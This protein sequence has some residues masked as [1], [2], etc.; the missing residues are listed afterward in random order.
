MKKAIFSWIGSLLTTIALSATSAL[1]Q[2]DGVDVSTP[3]IDALAF[4][5]N[6][7]FIARNLI[8]PFD[9]Q[10]T[11]AFTN[12][13]QLRAT[14]VG[15]N[16]GVAGFRFE[17]IDGATSLR[18]LASIIDL[19][20][21]SSI[22]FGNELYLRATNIIQRGTI[23]GPVDGL[24][25]I[26]GKSVDL[27]RGSLE[28][29]SGPDGQ[30]S[31]NA[32]PYFVPDFLIGDTYWGISNVTV[33]ANSLVTTN[34]GSSYIAR[35]PIFDVLSL[36][37]PAGFKDSI[38]ILNGKVFAFT[39]Q[40]T[41]TNQI[42]QVVVVGN[43]DTNINVSVT[44]AP[45]IHLDNNFKTVY[46]QLS[47]TVTNIIS[48]ATAIR[49]LILE[50]S[51]ASDTNS[52]YLTNFNNGLTV[53]PSNFILAR[54]GKTGTKGPNINFSPNL[55]KNYYDSTLFTNGTAYSN[56][57]VTNI[58]YSAYAA[59]VDYQLSTGLGLAGVSPTNTYGRIDIS[60]DNL[61]LDH[62]RI[63]S[64]QVTTIRAK[65]ISSTTASA[66]DAPFLYYDLGSTNGNLAVTNLAA[67]QIK[68][69]AQGG[70]RAFSA[71]F[72]NGVVYTPP[73]PPTN[74][75]STNTDG[76][77]TNAVIYE[78]DFH[79]LFVD[80]TLGLDALTQITG[81]SIRSTNAI[82]S[83]Q[84]SVSDSFQTF[85]DSLTIDGALSLG[86]AGSSILSRWSATNAPTLRFF[87]NHGV[88]T[89]LGGES[90]GRDRVQPYQSWV[91]TGTNLTTGALFN[92]LNWE[93]DGLLQSYFSGSVDI[94]ANYIKIGGGT[95][96]A[97]PQPGSI[98]NVLISGNY[99]KLNGAV[100]N[101]GNVV[102]GI[103]NSVSDAGIGDPNRISTAYG[104]TV[105]F[106]PSSGDLPGTTV[107][108][109]APKFQSP[110]VVW[111]G[112]DRGPNPAG[113]SDN[114]SVGKLR[115]TSQDQGFIT[116][117]PSTGTKAIYV[118]VLDIAPN[119]AAALDTF[120]AVDPNFTIYFADSTV[121]VSQ[122]DGAL[123]GRIQWVPRYAGQYSGV[124]VALQ[125][126][127]TVRVNRNLLN[128]PTI[129]S[130]GD[131]VVNAL[132]PHPF[133]GPK[134]TLLLTGAPLSGATLSWSGAA[135]TTYTVDVS[136]SLLG[137]DWTNL[138]TISNTNSSATTLT[139][140]DSITPGL[141][142]RFY[143]VSYTP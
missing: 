64:E 84:I 67:A 30:G 65:H 142:P 19:E 83:D 58:A 8:I 51:F 34:S 101:G 111:A 91:N 23:T 71:I 11:F 127:Q 121:P 117:S 118:D 15:P 110:G 3:T 100:L 119:I 115:L 128:S 26:E 79:I 120:L 47:S 44:F 63:R 54:T 38:S 28:I 22:T 59:T 1:Y 93:N 60:A 104:I 10:N 103:T 40:T 73:P 80:S 81:L 6:G 94:V 102:L 88:L 57:I 134:V 29:Q 52:A 108:V 17:H 74:S 70:I 107:E 132:D 122:L 24:I 31:F 99:L 106:K 25:H 68:R 5:N 78:T 85:S 53:R 20:P 124:N 33:N 12:R 131:G 97:A 92:A 69:F 35:T 50:D 130:N 95:V 87:T 90:F 9:T 4:V 41:K 55:F 36:A 37:L 2:N 105:P 133:D 62:A 49:Q 141:P 125:N 136:S 61:N 138:T 76:G 56:N 43:R 126:G 42:I 140:K 66:I 21:G 139:V 27:S 16:G 14:S 77:D 109:N 72:T 98:G 135:A 13:G 18:T 75:T 46:V 48:G 82:I 96:D 89:S 112:E 32:N 39:N 116:F 137:A 114:L 45:S 143:R 129:D 113:Y 86:S 7:I 123:G